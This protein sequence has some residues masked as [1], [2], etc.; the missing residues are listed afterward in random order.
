[1]C[2]MCDITGRDRFHISPEDYPNDGLDPQGF[3]PSTQDTN[4]SVKTTLNFNS[5]NNIIVTSGDGTTYRGLS[6]DD[7]YIISSKTIES[8]A[9]IDIIDTSGVNVI[10]LVDGLNISKSLFTSDATRLTLSNGAEI[11]ING[12]DKFTFELSANLT[13]GTLGISKTYAEFAEYMGIDSLPTSGSQ[14][15]NTNVTINELKTKT[16]KDLQTLLS[17]E[18]RTVQSTETLEIELEGYLTLPEIPDF[19]ESTTDL[20][21][22]D[23]LSGLD[24]IVLYQDYEKATIAIRAD[25]KG[26]KIFDTSF[27]NINPDYTHDKDFF[28]YYFW[29]YLGTEASNYNSWWQAEKIG[30]SNFLDNIFD[31]LEIEPNA[32]YLSPETYFDSDGES[33]HFKVIRVQE[34]LPVEEREGGFFMKEEPTYFGTENARKILLW[35]LDDND[36]W[37]NYTIRIDSVFDDSTDISIFQEK[38]EEFNSTAPDTIE[39]EIRDNSYPY[40]TRDQIKLNG[41]KLVIDGGETN[42]ETNSVKVTLRAYFKYS[43]GY[44]FENEEDGYEDITVT[45]KLSNNDFTRTQSSKI[46]EST[47]NSTSISIVEDNA[48][49]I[50]LDLKDFNIDPG[51]AQINDVKI[52]YYSSKSDFDQYL[53]EIFYIDENFLKF[54]EG[55]LYDYDGDQIVFIHHVRNDAND[56]NND[57]FRSTYI[58]VEG[59]SDIR[60]NDFEITFTYKSDGKD[61]EH[62]LKII[63]YKDSDSGTFITQDHVLNAETYITDN[64]YIN[65]LDSHS[66]FTHSNPDVDSTLLKEDEWNNYET[67]ITY[68]FSNAEKGNIPINSYSVFLDTCYFNPYIE[69]DTLWTPNE[70]A[71][72]MVREILDRT[73]E[74]FKITFTE[75][76][77]N[78]YDDAQIRFSFYE[79]TGG[80]VSYA[81]L[82][83]IAR[84]DV[85]LH[86]ERA[87]IFDDSSYFVISPQGDE[88]QTARHEV[89]HALGLSHP[90]RHFVKKNAIEDYDQNNYPEYYYA[91][92]LFTVMGYAE[93][94]DKGIDKYAEGEPKYYKHLV[95]SLVPQ[96]DFKLNDQVQVSPSEGNPL[97]SY[98]FRQSNWSRDDILT[99]GFKYGLRE[100]Y[101]AGDNTYSWNEDK[102]IYETL[103][104]MGGNDTIDLSN[105]D[106]DMKIDLNPG[107]VS[108]VGIN[109]KRLNFDRTIGDDSL[110]TGDVFI[111]SWSTVI[112]NY[113]GS[114]GS[115][116]VTL[117]TSVVNTINTGAGDDVIRNVL[118]T[119][120]VNAGAGSDTVYISYTNL[121]PNISVSIDGGSETSDFDWIICDL[122]PD[123]EKDFTLCRTA[124]V[125]FEGYDFTDG[126]K[127]TITLDTDDF[128]SINSQTLKIK[129][130]SNDEISLPQDAVQTSSDDLYLYYTLNDVE[131]G[132]STDLMII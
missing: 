60:N 48:G 69:N 122:A 36:D 45:V 14:S 11:T 3:R 54:S 131:I 25:K 74:L 59:G 38:I 6:G 39:Y 55:A 63:E 17:E 35:W 114:N 87:E 27:L 18:T 102:N 72:N 42:A 104:D 70:N 97:L 119:D 107:A 26:I 56:S 117:N 90:F 91:N 95:Y 110:K 82:P 15:G 101:N 126:E 33:Y 108:E 100:D 31:R 77:E 93:F 68:A 123:T 30:S 1:M 10:Q 84:T 121:D 105:Y 41:S 66:R 71:K 12:A 78:N 120:I 115:D 73:S 43:N 2:L 20:S 4:S 57:A 99:L 96:Y 65:A 23:D 128:V 111:L 49:D 37:Q 86:I 103:H 106:W 76:E 62:T 5:G 67:F 64:K 44:T 53:E 116:D 112:E 46:L 21:T 40:T 89:G 58:L 98:P 118:A 13:D 94:W 129:G 130:D 47:D 75:V 127:Q 79:T 24:S 29:Q 61:F 22:R 132:I 32:I 125:N 52:N 85:I 19:S 88:A 7:V 51:S 83:S 92:R 28:T 124:F 9:K 80:Y 50:L 8:N 113:I 34:R 109:Q 16:K 81:Y